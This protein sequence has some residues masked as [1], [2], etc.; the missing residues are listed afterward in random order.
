[1]LIIGLLIANEVRFHL[2]LTWVNE[3]ANSLKPQGLAYYARR[4]SERQIRA[5]S[6]I[7]PLMNFC[8]WNSPNGFLEPT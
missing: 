8:K 2:K 6:F 1:M 3:L 5:K 7:K 4:Q